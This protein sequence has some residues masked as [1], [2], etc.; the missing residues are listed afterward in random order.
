MHVIAWVA[1]AGAA[2]AVC[3][4]ELSALLSALLG[5]AFP[6]SIFLV[7]VLGCFLF[8]AA[9]TC[10]GARTELPPECRAAIMTGFLGAFTTF[11]TFVADSGALSGRGAWLPFVCNILGQVLLGL[12]ALRCGARLAAYIF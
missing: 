10:F 4:M 6:W 3:R 5:T 8:G 9:S 7:N 1:V 2:G 12:L 11:S